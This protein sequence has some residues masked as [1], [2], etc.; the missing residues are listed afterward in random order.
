MADPD[1]ALWIFVTGFLVGTFCS[2]FV[3]LILAF[4]KA[5]ARVI[6][7]QSPPNP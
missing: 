5:T 6:R 2:V 1:H 4:R 7:P 3:A